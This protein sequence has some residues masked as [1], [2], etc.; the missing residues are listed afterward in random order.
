MI[1]P[2]SLPH[3]EDAGMDTSLAIYGIKVMMLNF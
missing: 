1:L 3:S 2:L